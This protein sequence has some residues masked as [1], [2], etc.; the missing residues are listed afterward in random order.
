MH[1][2]G[3]FYITKFILVKCIARSRR[4]FPWDIFVKYCAKRLKYNG[5]CGKPVGVQSQLACQRRG[6]A[7][8]AEN[9][10]MRA[11]VARG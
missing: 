4:Y 9:V 6:A 2:H 1:R 5:A 10:V 7:G 8:K 11:S 3:R